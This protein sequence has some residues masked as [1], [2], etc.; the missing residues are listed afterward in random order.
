[1]SELDGGQVRRKALTYD[2]ERTLRGAGAIVPK[3]KTRHLR[4]CDQPK[5]KREDRSVTVKTADG[6]QYKLNS[7]LQ[8]KVRQSLPRTPIVRI[9]A[10]AP[11]KRSKFAAG[12]DYGETW[13]TKQSAQ[14]SARP[15]S[16]PKTEDEWRQALYG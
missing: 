15:T 14:P 8:Y 10:E 9:I 7:R 1:M 12:A 6:G 3:Q 11:T 4:V 2:E 5:R 16:V 13:Q